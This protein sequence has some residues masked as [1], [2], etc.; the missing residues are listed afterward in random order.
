VLNQRSELSARAIEIISDRANVVFFS[1]ASAW[2]IAIKAGLGKITLPQPADR[3][4][5]QQLVVNGFS[6]LPVATRHA[7][8]TIALPRHA[9]HKDP[10][11]R[12]LIAQ[13]NVEDLPVLTNDPL[14]N[15]YAVRIIW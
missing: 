10:F 6:E 13:S 2:E 3:F 4:I 7:L 1:A 5:E 14:F 9:D 12:I 11:D 8:R 15:R